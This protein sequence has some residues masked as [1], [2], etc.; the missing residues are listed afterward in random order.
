[1]LCNSDGVASSPGLPGKPGDEAS[2]GGNNLHVV[3][4]PMHSALGCRADT[5]HQ[6]SVIVPEWATTGK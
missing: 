5:T 1:M 4:W 2:D 3:G 6:V